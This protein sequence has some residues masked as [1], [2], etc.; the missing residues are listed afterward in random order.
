MKLTLKII[1]LI[2]PVICYSN[3][4]PSFSF[5]KDKGLR[6]I[7][8]SEKEL[9]KKNENPS[10]KVTEEIAQTTT[11]EAQTTT[12]EA[13]TTTE[14]A[15]TTTEEAQTTTE[16]AQTTT[17]EAQTTTTVQTETNSENI[18]AEE[19]EE[20]P[21]THSISEDFA[22][23]EP[24]KIKG[25][26]FLDSFIEDSSWFFQKKKSAHKVGITPNY[27]H[28][29]TEGH[30]LGLSFFSYS[31][32]KNGYYLNTTFN[33]YLFQPYSHLSLS[34]IGNREGL[35][36]AKAKLIYNDHH[37][38]YYGDTEQLEGM[39]ASLNQLTKIYARRFI[40]NYDLAYQEKNQDFYFGLGAKAFFRQ[41]R[42]KLQK[43]N[44]YFSNEAFVFLRAFTG[45]DTRN[46]LRD[47]TKG[48]FHQ[49]SFGCKANLSYSDSFCQGNGDFRF[50]FP[51]F[52]ETDFIPFKN[53]ILALRAFIG[54]SFISSSYATK[55]SLGRYSFFQD[56]N[57]LR[58]FKRNR[59]IGDKIYFA[60]T[61]L[62]WPIWD[63]YLQGIIFL[64]L[65]ET[66]TAN[67]AFND[68]VFDYGGGLRF[69]F[70]PQYDLKLRLD[71]GTGRDLQGKRNY[72]FTI[73]FLQVF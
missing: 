57:T 40:I 42:T 41:E 49:V 4:S 31:P 18:P 27:S 70:P 59:F 54:S 20:T 51:L 73:S 47:P 30:R 36:R 50:Y 72:D 6:E 26:G 67:Q 45:F 38:N 21:I 19:M 25:A 60:Q 5:S 14:E 8:S 33:K 35:F 16:E 55:Y 13:Q 64:E 3:S 63:K 12:E 1:F 2:S 24:E 69:G 39:Q 29:S 61:E 10:I 65:G 48:A 43:N 23:Q 56:T 7:S 71:W 53:S 15:Q 62:R 58:G 37:E 66:A 32:K 52:E 17:E 9:L 46:N 68:F 28:D 34:Y 22:P 44:Q 11:E